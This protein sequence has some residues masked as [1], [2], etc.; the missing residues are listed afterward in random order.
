VLEKN[1]PS[2][3]THELYRPEVDFDNSLSL[4]STASKKY[5]K[6]TDSSK[7]SNSAKDKSS[8]KLDPKADVRNRVDVCVPAEKAK[9]KKDHFPI[10]NESHARN[11]LA[12]VAK[13]TNA[14]AWYDGSL[15]SLVN[16]VKKKV[17]AKY[18][19]I[20][21][22]EKKSD[23]KKKASSYYENVLRKLGQTGPRE[24]D[25]VRGPLGDV[26]PVNSE[27]AKQIINHNLIENVKT[28]YVYP[29]RKLET[30]ERHDPANEINFGG[31]YVDLDH[32]AASTPATTPKAAPPAPKNYLMGPEVTAFQN[33]SVQRGEGAEL[34]PAGADG[35]LGDKTM[36]VLKKRFPGTTP[37]EL[38]GNFMRGG[39]SMPTKAP[40]TVAALENAF[41]KKLS[42]MQMQTDSLKNQPKIDNDAAG[43]AGQSWYITKVQEYLKQQGEKLPRF[44]ADGKMGNETKTALKNWQ[45]KNKLNPSGELDYE[46]LQKLET[47]PFIN[48]NAQNPTQP[49][50]EDFQSKTINET[51]NAISAYFTELSTQAQQGKITAQ[52][53]P[54]FKTQ[55]DQYGKSLQESMGSIMAAIQNKE[56]DQEDRKQAY[57]LYEK[58]NKLLKTLGVWNTYFGDVSTVASLESEFFKKLGR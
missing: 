50:Y 40:G 30:F 58:G 56:T 22:D 26:Y 17:H 39:L 38:L 51:L 27:A 9:D 15:S 49:D 33:W 21:K 10:N 6:K 42:Q 36:A 13:F 25:G 7:D 16:L 28:D 8:K 19:N 32:P 20:G 24:P 12:Q 43:K 53:K 54:Q 1:L 48:P 37:Q 52:L 3:S 35:K 14:P 47:I 31:R 57:L 46:T 45:T 29:K 11:A 34:G 2:S 18:P 55:V 23:K 4:D 5:P 41:F 44:G